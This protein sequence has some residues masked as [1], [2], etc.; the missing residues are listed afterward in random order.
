MNMSHVTVRSISYL[1]IDLQNMT[2]NELTDVVVM[3]TN[4]M[5]SF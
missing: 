2:S 4:A 5:C 1:H 3:H